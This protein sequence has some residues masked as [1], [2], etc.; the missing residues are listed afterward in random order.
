MVKLEILKTD[1]TTS[2]T[3]DEPKLSQLRC[4]E[5]QKQFE[6]AKKEGKS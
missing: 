1:L 2:I 5:W 6:K 4:E 3:F